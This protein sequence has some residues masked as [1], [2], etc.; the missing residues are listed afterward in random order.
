MSKIASALS[1]LRRMEAAAAD[2][3][4]LHTLHPLTKLIL[5]VV[6]LACVVSIHRY[7]V[8]SLIV[9]GLYPVAAF[10]LGNLSWAD[11]W[12]RLRYIL[13]FV[14]CVGILNPFFDSQPINLFGQ[15]VRGGFISLVT[16]FLKGLLTVLATYTLIAS[17]SIEKICFALKV[18]HVPSVIITQVLL[19]YRYLHLLLEEANRITQAYELR[20]PNASGIA[21][22]QWGGLVGKFLLR[23]VDRA[24]Q[25]YNSM[26]LRGF[27]GD[28]SHCGTRVRFGKLDVIFF[29]SCLI[30]LVGTKL[31]SN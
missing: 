11:A 1:E 3:T 19:T 7:D 15:L 21:M 29:A 20:A 2:K 12:R 4:F 22:G 28:F 26:L 5:T 13:P 9:L 10:A 25:V 24:E 23:S 31:M 16:L 6:Y 14:A 17:T 18:L 27:A 30:F 8:K